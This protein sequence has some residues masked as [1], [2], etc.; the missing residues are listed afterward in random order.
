MPS[1]R[2]GTDTIGTEGGRRMAKPATPGKSPP[3]WIWPAMAFVTIGFFL[4]YLWWATRESE[5][6]IVEE[7]P[8]GRST[9]SATAEVF[10]SRPARFSGRLVRL[11]SVLVVE[12][13][14]RAAFGIELPNR[15]LYPV[16]LERH[17]I[18]AEVQVT[19]QD[20]VNLVGSVYALND[21]VIATWAAR[22]ILHPAQQSRLASDSTFLLADSVEILI[23]PRPG[24]STG[25]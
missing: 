3:A 22:G 15:P 1:G 18:E 14:G 23:P 17:L 21:S 24:G 5:V 6:R 10:A 8:G 25:S 12:R 2:G 7:T 9:V 4:G 16:V 11:D 20:L 19:H 13:L